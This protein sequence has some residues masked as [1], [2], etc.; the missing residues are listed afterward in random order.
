MSLLFLSNVNA[1]MGVRLRRSVVRSSTE[2]FIDREIGL[3]TARIY[4]FLWEGEYEAGDGK[5]LPLRGNISTLANV[6]GLIPLQKYII[7]NC[8]HMST[9][10]PGTRQ[11]R[12]M[13]NHVDFASH[14][15]Y[16]C[17][18]FAAVAPGGRHS[19]LGVALCR[20]CRNDSG[21]LS[22]STSGFRLWIGYNSPSLYPI[23]GDAAEV[24]EIDF[25]EYDLRRRMA[26]RDPLCCLM[27]LRVMVGPVFP[28]LYG[29]RMCPNCPHCALSG[30]HCMDICGSN[31]TPMGGGLGRVDTIVGA[32]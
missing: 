3:A 7:Q 16:G 29:W 28:N 5:R 21:L 9:R 4:Q 25:P 31:A 10:I 26:G 18:L 13:I 6:V 12:R 19:G 8:V 1:G 15:I 22:S 17:L 11:I 20:Y 32:I 14:A 2:D 27:A 24:V 30:G 23:D